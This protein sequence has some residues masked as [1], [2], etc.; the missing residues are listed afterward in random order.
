MTLA[1][2]PPPPLPPS[3]IIPTLGSITHSIHPLMGGAPK[4]ISLHDTSRTVP[5]SMYCYHFQDAT[6]AP[7]QLKIET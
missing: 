4:T 5:R 6:E 3:V 1:S 2:L 7:K